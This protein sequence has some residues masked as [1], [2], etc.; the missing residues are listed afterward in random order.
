MNIERDVPQEC[1]VCKKFP[2]CLAVFAKLKP[3]DLAW[4][5]RISNSLF[6]EKDQSIF[7]QG[8]LAHEVFILCQGKVQLIRS[9][10]GQTRAVQ[11]L[12]AGDVVGTAALMGQS[13]HYTC[14]VALEAS[15]VRLIPVGD[16]REL[17]DRSPAAARSVLD[18][19][20]S[21]LE[22]SRKFAYTLLR[23]GSRGKVI[24][25]LLELSDIYGQRTGQNGVE[26]KA[27]F[28]DSHLARMI[29]LSREMTN[30]QLNNL[31]S[32]GLILRKDH[33]WTILD[34]EGLKQL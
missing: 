33:R 21:Q 8:G 13:H 7:V 32:R 5:Q 4:L 26:I 17:C 23:S 16:F 14:A 6:L 30:R 10:N 18:N 1:P 31:K 11:F 9:E 19:L 20:A 22:R 29:G 25:L 28:T 24:G 2:P 3:T 27:R 12:R 15:C 34:E